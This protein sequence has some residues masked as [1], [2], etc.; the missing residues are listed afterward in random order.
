MKRS[1]AALFCAIA[2][3]G[4]SSAPDNAGATTASNSDSATFVQADTAFHAFSPAG[5]ENRSV[6]IDSAMRERLSWA[7]VLVTQYISLTDNTAVQ[8][9]A[10]DSSIA[11]LWDQLLDTDSAK[12]MVCHLG[13]DYEDDYGKRFIT[14]GWLYIDTLTHQV[15]EYD[16]P[17][18]SLIVWNH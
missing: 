18:D 17:D 14:D 15:Y 9:A 5:K 13:H 6:E 3:A 16:V 7:D 12:Y 11:W 8:N 10:K 1:L 4:C 2:F